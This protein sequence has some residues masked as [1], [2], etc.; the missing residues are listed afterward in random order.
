MLDKSPRLKASKPV[1]QQKKRK[2]YVAGPRDVFPKLPKPAALTEPEPILAPQWEEAEMPLRSTL[3]RKTQAAAPASEVI[4]PKV[5]APIELESEPSSTA[6]Q[7]T[8]QADTELAEV[9]QNANTSNVEGEAQGRELI[10]QP[11]TP[12]MDLAQDVTISLQFEVTA[13]GRVTNIFPLVKGNGQLEKIAIG[14]LAQYR[15]ESAA[16]GTGNQQGIIHFTITRRP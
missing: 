10:Y 5:T 13:D 15:F 9:A 2:K 1:V 16:T 6:S 11:I 14:L 7:T 4:E 8:S 3:R 12:P